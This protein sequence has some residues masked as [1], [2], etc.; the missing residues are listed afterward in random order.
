MFPAVVACPISP[1]VAFKVIGEVADI[2]T[3]PLAS[4]IVSVLVLFPVMPDNCNWSFLVLSDSSWKYMVESVNVELV[5]TPEV[6]MSMPLEDSWNV[7]EPA[8]MFTLVEPSPIVKLP[9]SVP[10]SVV[11]L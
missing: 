2:A 7:P 9:P 1:V 3:V 6:D 4:G 5:I 8:F 10:V 11:W